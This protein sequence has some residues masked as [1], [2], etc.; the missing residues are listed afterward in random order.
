M[1]AHEDE[2]ERVVLR[3]TVGRRAAS[4]H[5]A[6]RSSRRRRA[7]SRR[8]WSTMRR[9][10]TRMSHAERVVGLA[11]G[12]ATWSRPRAA[13]PAPRPPRRRS[14]RSGGRPHRGPAARA[15]AAGPRCSWRR[16][17]TSGSGA[18][19]TWR[20]SMG[21]RIGTPFGPGA[22]DACAAISMRPIERLDVDHPVAGEQLLGLGVRAVGDH[23]RADAVGHHELGLLGSGETLG[24][25][26]LARSSE[27]LVQRLLELDVG[28]DVLGGPLGHRRAVGLDL[29]VVL[30]QHE[31]H[32]FILPRPAPRWRRSPRCRSC[33]RVLDIGQFAERDLGPGAVGR[34]RV[35]RASA[36][37]VPIRRCGRWPSRK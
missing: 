15:R 32:R 12:R 24:V 11:V 27:L 16:A 3:P 35:P 19:I 25:D 18:P 14:R 29:S 36:S 22:A 6:A 9:D 5:D 7:S 31:S 1:A 28:L 26:Q 17:H 21:S 20:T 8:Y 4:D 37:A 23:R 10:A 30:Q 13:P 2:D 33:D 34:R